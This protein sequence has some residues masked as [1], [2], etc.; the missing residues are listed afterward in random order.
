MNIAWLFR[1]DCQS[2]AAFGA[3]TLEN[4]PAV[5]GA[6]PNPE[7]VR[8]ASATAI[9]LKRALHCA[10]GSSG[11]SVTPGWAGNVLRKHGS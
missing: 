9:W 3:A 5:L 1:R 11:F 8:A 6:H 4:D 10:P 2:L 7:S